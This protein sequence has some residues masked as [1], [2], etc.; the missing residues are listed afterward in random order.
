[1][2]FAER[3]DPRYVLDLVKRVTAVSVRTVEI[4]RAL[5]SLPDCP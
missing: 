3:G 4:V 1:M 2:P 5:P